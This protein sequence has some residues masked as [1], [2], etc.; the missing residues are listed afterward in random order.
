MV[1][2]DVNYIP[3]PQENEDLSF[4][5]I[6]KVADNTIKLVDV[7]KYQNLLG[8]KKL[9]AIWPSTTTTTII[10]RTEIRCNAERLAG[11]KIDKLVTYCKEVKKFV[12]RSLRGS[13][14]EL[15]SVLSME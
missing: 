15:L 9:W 14:F 4:I 1:F 5:E 3:N 6:L 12:L 8:K 2:F 10:W 7:L 11:E 13:L